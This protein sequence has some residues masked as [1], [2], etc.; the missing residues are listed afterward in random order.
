[1]TIR[2]PGSR[3]KITKDKNLCR[4]TNESAEILQKVASSA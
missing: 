1:M 3:D 2:A 4:F